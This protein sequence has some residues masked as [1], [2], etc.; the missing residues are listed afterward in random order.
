MS[1]IFLGIVLAVGALFVVNDRVFV[2]GVEETIGNVN[3]SDVMNSFFNEFQFD[4]HYNFIDISSTPN[5]VQTFEN[6][7]KIVSNSSYISI[8]IEEA[9]VNKV[10]VF[11]TSSVYSSLET[12]DRNQLYSTDGILYFESATNSN[13]QKGQGELLIQ[14]P[15]GS[16]FDLDIDLN[17]GE[18]N[19]ATSAGNELILTS[20]FSDINIEAPFNEIEI[21]ID[22]GSINFEIDQNTTQLEIMLE[23]S[24]A[25]V[26]VHE[27]TLFNVDT[28]MDFGSCNILAPTSSAGFTAKA[29]GGFSDITFN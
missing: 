20:S 12:L 7:T 28:D 14:V 3:I 21:E 27:G 9:D 10:T 24:D 1:K 2:N 13:V 16:N 18:L 8:N 29:V 6:I 19:Y 25:I 23:F 26:K 5:G 17:F 11:D 15:K 4:I 22:F